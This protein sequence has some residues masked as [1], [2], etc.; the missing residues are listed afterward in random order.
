M[1][2]LLA[3][4]FLLVPGLLFAQTSTKLYVTYDG[5]IDATVAL[6]PTSE[7]DQYLIEFDGFDHAY[8][9]A[10][11]LYQRKPAGAH[12]HWY[13]MIGVGEVNFRNEGR[14]ALVLGTSVQYQEVY[15]P[16]V[17]P[18]R[19]L[20][21]SEVAPGHQERMR[22]QY[23]KQQGV[24]KSKVKAKKA[25]ASAV[26][27]FHASCGSSL[28]VNVDWSAFE[29]INQKTTPALGVHYLDSLRA[30]C[31]IDNDYKDVVTGITELAFVTEESAGKQAAALEGGKMTITL[32]K[33][34][35]NVSRSSYRILYEL[36]N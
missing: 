6:L 16:D 33:D 7:K 23:E 31:A 9:E 22:Q 32:S 25:I 21:K 4:L 8:D 5:D 12:G 3:T 10:V 2:K 29:S 27:S 24:V 18:V 34:A 28:N 17:A 35:P 20:Y 15:L 36:I 30:I 26:E 13:E 11:F 19:V 1:Y 14:R